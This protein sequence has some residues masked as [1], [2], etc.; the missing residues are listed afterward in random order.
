VAKKEMAKIPLLSQWMK[1]IHCLF[2]DRENVK[3]GLK[4]ILQAIANVKDG[5][6]V[7]ICPEGT[8]NHGE[9]MLPFREGS[10]KIAEKSECPVIPAAFS[11]TDDIFENHLPFIRRTHVTIQFGVPTEVSGL[12]KEE[13]RVLGRQVQEE[14]M[15][16]LQ[17]TAESGQWS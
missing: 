9:D 4:T 2:L 17:T 8:R 11:H 7:W 5:K 13:K 16:L 1:N 12:T 14:I 10:F 3:D 15:T 6:S